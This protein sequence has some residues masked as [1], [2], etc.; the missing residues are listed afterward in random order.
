ML[1]PDLQVVYE[2]NHLIIVNKPAGTLVQAD[3]TGDLPLSAMVESYL[4][5]KYHKTGNAFVGVVHR[6]DRPVSGIVVFAKTSKA[7]SRLNAL[8]REEKV[9][10]TYLA[11]STRKP[12]KDQDVL[13]HWLKKDSRMKFSIAFA[14]DT[15]HALRAEL[16]FEIKQVQLPYYLWEIKPKTGRFHQIRCQLAKI[17]SPIV[18]DLKYGFSVPNTDKSICLHAYSIQFDHPIS[19]VA[20]SLTCAPPASNAWKVFSY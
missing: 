20:L 12:L 6:I 17:G 11:I 4:K 2:D 13:V 7:L 3:D 14:R 15:P 18:G 9:H 8:W 16:S 19:G 5:Q 1:H 10:K